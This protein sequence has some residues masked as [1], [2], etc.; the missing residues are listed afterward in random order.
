MFSR[1]K[2]LPV[3]KSTD[4][5]DEINLF[6]PDGSVRRKYRGQMLG[7]ALFFLGRKCAWKTCECDSCIV[8]RE[9]LAQTNPQT[10]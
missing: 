4:G 10:P 3:A 5:R 9:F 1:P 8:A 2:P 6:N 7:M